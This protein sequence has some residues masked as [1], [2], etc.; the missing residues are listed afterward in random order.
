MKNTLTKEDLEGIEDFK[1]DHKR[2]VKANFTKHGEGI[3]IVGI[4]AKN[5]MPAEENKKYAIFLIPIPDEVMVKEKK[6]EVIKVIMLAFNKLENE[7][8]TPLCYSW[9]SEVWMRISKKEE[10]LENIEDLEKE[11]RLFTSFETLEGSEVFLEKVIRHG[12]TAN[13]KGELI[14][15]VTFEEDVEHSSSG[16]EDVKIGG[17]FGNLLKKYHELKEE[18]ETLTEGLK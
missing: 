5:T 12:K 6:D 3:P 18:F 9:S 2:N 13:D 1:N 16:K 14:D 8:F 10:N 4:F 17:V 11:E 7:G 15:C